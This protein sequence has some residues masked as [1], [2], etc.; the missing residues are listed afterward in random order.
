MNGRTVASVPRGCSTVGVLLRSLDVQ[1]SRGEAARSTR[2]AM[3]PYH[4]LPPTGRRRPPGARPVPHAPRPPPSPRFAVVGL[5]MTALHLV[6]FTLVL[7]WSVPETAN[8]VAFLTAPQV[9]FAL[10]YSW[11]WSSRR[12][13]GRETVGYVIRRAFL[14][15]G[16]ALLGFSLN[17][18]VFSTAYRIVGMP[19]LGGA[20][21]APARCGLTAGV[22]PP[23]CR[24]VGMPRLGSAV[25]AT[26]ASAAA[27][28][29]LSS[30][31]VF[32]R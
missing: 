19:P 3:T 2:R 14:F 26:A 28:F 29:L 8:V 15:N 1:A 20:R 22:F 4:S 25:V 6:I 11:T 30:R 7:P 12:P 21:G 10:S 16:S 24:I 9:N 17:A 23:A 31:V 27:S 5:A 13:P 18:V 32:T